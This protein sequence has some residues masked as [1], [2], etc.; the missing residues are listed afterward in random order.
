MNQVRLRRRSLNGVLLFDKPLGWSSNDAV[1]RLRG[2]FNAE[3]A[4]HTGTLDPL[5]TG[6]LPV[7]FGEATKFSADL[8]D[9]DK[10][11]V[12]RVR[13]GCSTSTGDLEG[14]SVKHAPDQSFRQLTFA[15]IDRV[16]RGFEGDQQQVPPMYSALK[17]DGRALYEYAREG[18]EVER[19]ARSIHIGAIRLVEVFHGNVTADGQTVSE[20][21][22]AVTCSKGTYIR[23]LAEDIG[24]K[25]GCFAHLSGLRR[26]AVGDL[27][28]DGRARTWDALCE[29]AV[30]VQSGV[31]HVA[32]V[33]VPN[34]MPD[35]ASG[36]VKDEA[37]H[38]ASPPRPPRLR[39]DDAQV[40]E[41]LAP[42]DS[43][44]SSLPAIE[45]VPELAQ[46]FTQGQRLPLGSRTEQGRVRVYRAHPPAL[47][48][49]GFLNNDG[50]GN[51]LLCPE[52]LV[53]EQSS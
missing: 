43:L 13:L 2:L 27:Q 53:R 10:T 9:A 15:Q 4:G 45:L 29:Q 7:L 48:G 8:L 14:E 18:V 22:M 16:L 19:Q 1:Q 47:L 31:Q 28:L 17:R 33:N 32:Q 12:A 20:F 39:L 51:S 30:Q 25:L 24:E 6:L 38:S 42:V 3:K 26:T 34:K 36:A 41:H 5:A 52:R 11:Y 44:L 46:R 50:A 21:D 23:V 37:R 49:T 40:D 35:Q